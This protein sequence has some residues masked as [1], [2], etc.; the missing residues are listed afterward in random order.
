PGCP[1]S[2]AIFGHETADADRNGV[3]PRPLFPSRHYGDLFSAFASAS[4][5]GS[6]YVAGATVLAFQSGNDR[7][8]FAFPSPASAGTRTGPW[9]RRPQ[10]LPRVTW[11]FGTTLSGVL[12]GNSTSTRGP[13][14]SGTSS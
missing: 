13:I 10:H 6:S 3:D 7:V 4:T 12:P 11:T 1:A 9:K 2:A 14:P 5:R 8:T